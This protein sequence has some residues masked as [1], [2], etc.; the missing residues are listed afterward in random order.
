[1]AGE[2][3]DVL[4]KRS[5]ADAIL[6]STARQLTQILHEVAGQL[7]PFPPFLDS[8]TT[9]AVEAE[10]GAAVH[11]DRGCVVAMQDGELYEYT[12]TLD[13]TGDMPGFER[14][15]ETKKL[16]LPPVDYIP[17]AYNAICEL[18]RMIQE[19]RASGKTNA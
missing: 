18:V 12:Y 14:K 10:P 4:A 16:D 3:I 2:G 15:E 9:R 5:M 11:A 1:M 13:M 8:V 7:D 17:Y 19:K 6:D